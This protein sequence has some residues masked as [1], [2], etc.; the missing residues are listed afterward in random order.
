MKI[1]MVLE[2]QFP[3][4]E[5]V[6]KEATSLIEK[7]YDVEILS[8]NYDGLPKNEVVSGI[9][10]FRFKI[11]RKAYNKLSPTHRVLPFYYWKWKKALKAHMKDRQVDVIHIHDLPLAN[12]GSWAKRKWGLKLVL[13]QH[14]LWS[15]TVKHYR[16]YNTIV[17]KFVRAFSCWTRYEKKQFKHA[18]KI[19]TVEEPIKQ[20]YLDHTSSLG[21]D[22]IV[23]PNTPLKKQIDDIVFKEREDKDSFVLY[24][25]GK[26]D[27][28]RYID[29]VVKAL[30]E[31][32]KRIPEIKFNIAGN[33]A[34]ACD[35][36]IWAKENNVEE[37][38]NYLGQLSYKD[39][40][41]QM[42]DADICVSLLPSYSEEL[43]RT[44]VTK[45]YQYVQLKKPM[46]VSRTDYIR[47]FVRKHEI[48]SVVNE[49]DPESIINE[50]YALYDNKDKMKKYSDN[51]EKIKNEL[52]WE[53]TVNS[54]IKMY[55]E[56]GIS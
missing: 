26:I 4:D 8:F 23:V 9:N 10:V 18:D 37:Y 30:P 54:L 19:I 7:G 32:S 29:T 40:M 45:I 21:K 2:R 28:N 53:K 38:V 49:T 14:E 51:C 34:K 48:G 15:E 11:S 42:H 47:E 56:M 36:R 27:H 31:L 46:L 52:V 25:A 24:Y 20:W 41:Q 3:F 39:M 33:I 43:N 12:L 1:L 17:G 55:Q 44:I 50:V 13:D 22:I 16:H 35:P 6:E 5:R